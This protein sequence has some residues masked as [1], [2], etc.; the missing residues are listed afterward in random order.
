MHRPPDWRPAFGQVGAAQ[1]HLEQQGVSVGD[2]FLFFGWFRD[3]IRN[4][5]GRWKY[6][7]RASP[8]TACSVGC[9]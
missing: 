4:T 9:R 6:N 3:V 8:S 5:D 2:V 7:P 1:K